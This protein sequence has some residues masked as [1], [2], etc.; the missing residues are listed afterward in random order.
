[1]FKPMLT[2]VGDKLG[3][4]SLAAASLFLT[5]PTGLDFLRRFAWRAA[6][7]GIG[8]A[9]RTPLRPLLPALL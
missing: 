4:S 6:I 2:S 1:M 8:V 5:A 3:L 7:A 9:R